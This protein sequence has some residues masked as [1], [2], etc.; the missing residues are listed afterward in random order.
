MGL[1]VIIASGD[2]EPAV[3][4]AARALGIPRAHARLTP[5][6]KIRLLRGPARRVAAACS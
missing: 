1:S 3:A 2:A 6:D 5:H 4:E